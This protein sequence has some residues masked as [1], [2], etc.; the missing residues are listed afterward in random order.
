MERAAKIAVERNL[1]FTLGRIDAQKYMDVASDHDIK[2]VPTFVLF[3]DGVATKFPSLHTAEAMLA[4]ERE[5]TC[6][7]A[8]AE[9]VAGVDGEVQCFACG[10]AHSIVQHNQWRATFR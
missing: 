6:Y 4:G 10:W 9:A 2:N 5:R 3:R 8:D 7:K 1:G